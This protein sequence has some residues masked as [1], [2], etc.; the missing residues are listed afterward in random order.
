MPVDRSFT[1]TGGAESILLTD[2]GT[3]ANNVSRVDSTLGEVVSFVHPTG[4]L[5]INGGSGADIIDIQN[6][7][8][9]TPIPDLIVNGG[10]ENDQILLDLLPAGSFGTRTINGDAGNDSIFGSSEVDTINGG[11][12]DDSIFGLGGDDIQNGGSGNDNFTWN[13]GDGADDTTGGTGTD[14]FTFNGAPGGAGDNI[15]VTSGGGFGPGANTL[16]GSEFAISRID[17]SNFA[18]EF[19]GVEVANVN[20]LSGEDIFNVGDLSGQPS[21]QTL[22]L[23][24]GL[25]NDTFS[26]SL[27]TTVQINVDGNDPVAPAVPGD[28]LIINAPEELNLFSDKA[29]SVSA[30]STIAGT[31]TIPV[32]FTSIETTQMRTGNGVVNLIGDNNNPTISQPDNFVVVGQ[33]VDAGLGDVGSDADGTNEFV[34]EINGNNPIAVRG[35]SFLNAFGDDQNPAPGAPDPALDTLEIT[36]YADSTPRSWGIDV[37]FNEGLPDGADG[38]QVDL[39]IYNTAAFG[40]GASEDIRIRPAGPDNGELVV[41]DL[42]FGTPIVD[43]DYVANTDIIVND[44]DGFLHDT[45][46]LTLLGT[47]PDNPGTSGNE[48]VAADFTAAGGAGTPWI[49]VRDGITPLYQVRSFT[50]FDSLDFNLLGGDDRLSITPDSGNANGLQNLVINYDGGDPVASDEL[51]LLVATNARVTQGAVST[52][53]LIDTAG[54]GDINYINTEFVNVNSETPGSSLIVRATDDNDTI[55]FQPVSTAGRVW[56]NDG[57][58]V[59]A[60]LADLNFSGVILDGRFGSDEFSV[61]PS[62]T[63]AVTV[64]GGDPTA[65]DSVVVNGDAGLNTVTYTPNSDDQGLVEIV[66]FANV[67]LGDV[68]HFTFDGQDGNDDVTVVGPGAF[69]HTLGSAIDDGQLQLDSRLALNYENLGLAG[70]VRAEGT[71]FGDALSLLT[72]PTIDSVDTFSLGA[73][74]NVGFA[75]SSGIGGHIPI[76]TLGVENY[77]VDISQTGNDEVRFNG[78]IDVS[79]NFTVAGEG[80]TDSVSLISQPG[81]VS[82][83]IAPSP[84]PGRTDVTGFGTPLNML[85]ISQINY[86][87]MDTDNLRVDPG[88]GDNVSRLARGTDFDLLTS[89]TLPTVAFV[90]VDTFQLTNSGGDDVF[91]VQPSSLAGAANYSTTG[92]AED[93]LRIVGTHQDDVLDLELGLITTNGVDLAVGGYGGIHLDTLGGDDSATIDNTAGLLTVPVTYDGG[94]GSDVLALTGTTAVTTATYRP[95]PSITEG[96]ITHDTMTVDF[97]GLEPVQDNVAAVN[98]FVNGTNAD[99]AIDYSAGLG[100][101]IFVGATGIV[102][103]DGFETIEFNNKAEPDRSAD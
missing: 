14:T 46:T 87:G 18:L 41:T 22:N 47:N 66:G 30:T 89:D 71:S 16:L 21:L 50:G 37:F 65:S 13:N 63:I 51:D 74:D 75:I 36:P 38:D 20:T 29:G 42:N 55:A 34:V 17:P 10:D 49:S 73:T 91:E 67:L 6:T 25:N 5:T 101:G 9:A 3:A 56:I 76:E 92:L 48:F 88:A 59:T 31:P 8:N 99:N 79:G 61:T 11:S 80:T 2:D 54:I 28:T 24:G 70:V 40:G 77:L 35:V 44:N 33:D 23:D 32:T 103:V 90:A 97:V 15:F 27:N 19:V 60:N 82:V 78:G 1:F 4:S 94:N 52:T 69:V 64:D 86:S 95:G 81:I 93:F 62:Q 39:L 43:I 96:R 98:L 57:T 53:G 72:S 102:S 83:T 68:E 26:V 100:G 12:E 58:I 84:D 7:D 45:D 85:G